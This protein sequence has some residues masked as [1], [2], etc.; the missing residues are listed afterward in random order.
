MLTTFL[1]PA[2]LAG[3]L[4]VT[5][6]TAP[7]TPSTYREGA[8]ATT[9]VLRRG[10]FARAVAVGNGEV[11]VGEP[12][13]SMRP[14]VVYVYRKDAAGRWAEAARITAA[15]AAVGDGFGAALD[16]DGNRLLVG[17][18]NE[19]AMA[20]SSAFI[21]ERDASG[22]WRQVARL[23]SPEGAL[24]FGVSVALSG[25]LA[26]V[27]APL[28]GGSMLTGGRGAVYVFRRSAGGE[29]TRAAQLTA[30]DATGQTVLGVSIDLSG[31]D[32]LAASRGA[33]IYAFRRA[34]SDWQ[35]TGT[36]TLEGRQPQ[37]RFG[38]SFVLTAGG[39]LVGAPGS[40]DG[41]G[42]VFRFRRDAA[43]GRWV[44]DG[45]LTA[46]DST[47]RQAFGSRLAT[48]GRT[49]LVGAGRAETGGAVF[50]LH[51]DAR[52]EWVDATRIQPPG[53]ARDDEFG[54]ALA[55]NGTVAAAGLTGADFGAGKA[56][57]L[58]GASWMPVATLVSEAE[59]LEAVTGSET[60][61]VAGTAN[62]F[63]CGQVDL[64]AFLP[65]QQIGGGRGVHLN[66]IWGWTDPQGSKEYALV[67][68]I[69]GTSFVDIS[70]PVRPV[71][72]G[73]LPMTEGATANAWRDIKVYRDHAFIVADGAGE[74]GM[75]VFDLAKLR[76][77]RGTPITSR[78]TRRTTALPAPTTS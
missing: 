32:L 40:A 60:R 42:R 69:D 72:V 23:S 71:Y 51:P 19:N 47:V 13:N 50:A 22:T 20:N 58:E 77:Y 46:P 39:V 9:S 7:T 17:A 6:L 63:S 10:G 70:D 25:D 3:L 62:R 67:G 8:A 33:G 43:T 48:D 14:G 41:S 52:G 54:G 26:A 37:D 45:Q 30:S 34:G 15:N 65:I 12:D 18:F 49:L 55:V 66:D 59:A 74:H 16:L 21:F 27:G 28:D 29:W 78:R 2:T 64:L 35:Q 31:D 36:L 44:Q 76:Q 57:I 5:F 11:L 53:L 61:C 4:P 1:L 38:A 73:Q 68:R 24:G 75:Q 56:M